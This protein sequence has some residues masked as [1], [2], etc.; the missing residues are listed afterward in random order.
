M[1]T[2]SPTPTV[3]RIPR[4]VDGGTWYASVTTENGTIGATGR[5]KKAALAYFQDQWIRFSS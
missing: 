5:T 4:T 3:E 2:T 1:N